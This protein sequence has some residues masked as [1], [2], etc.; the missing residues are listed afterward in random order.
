MTGPSPSQI[1]QAEDYTHHYDAPDPVAGLTPP[2][3]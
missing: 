1:F 2:G 3:R